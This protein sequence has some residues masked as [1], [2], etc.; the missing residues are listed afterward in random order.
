MSLFTV[1]NNS[2]LSYSE[3]GLSIFSAVLH[4]VACHVVTPRNKCD[5]CFVE[6]CVEN[7]GRDVLSAHIFLVK[8]IA[9]QQ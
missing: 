5:E 6:K 4:H 9:V 1:Y 2:S 8:F 7:C 3:P